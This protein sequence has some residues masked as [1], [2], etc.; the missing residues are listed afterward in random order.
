[1]KI[2]EFN[3]INKLVKT[4]EQR[5][6]ITELSISDINKKILSDNCGSQEVDYIYYITLCV[7]QATYREILAEIIKVL[8]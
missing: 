5:E 3:A 7:R 2:E 8:S 1:M 4:I 6:N